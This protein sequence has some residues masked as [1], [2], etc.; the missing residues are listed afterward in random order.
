MHWSDYTHSICIKEA[1]TPYTFLEKL[2]ILFGN[3]GNK[4]ITPKRSVERL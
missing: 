1:G 4:P 3:K 2:S